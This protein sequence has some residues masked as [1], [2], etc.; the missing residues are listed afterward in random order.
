MSMSKRLHIIMQ[1]EE[2]DALRRCAEREGLTLSEWARRALRRAQ[3]S[4]KGLTSDQK[5][6]ALDRALQCGHPTADIDEILVSIQKG[7][8]LH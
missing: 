1:D 5:L 6:K 3:R 4:Q 2:V 8:G 7:R